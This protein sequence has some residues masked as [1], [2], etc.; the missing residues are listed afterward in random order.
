MFLK[1][2]KIILASQSPRRKEIFEKFGF[3]VEVKYPP[4]D[5]LEIHPDGSEPWIPEEIVCENAI[6]KVESIFPVENQW[7]VGSDTL[8]VLNHKAYGKPKDQEEAFAFLSELSGHTHQVYSGFCLKYNNQ[9]L[10]GW[11]QASVTFKKLSTKEIQHYVE[12]IPVLDKA[13]AYAVQEGGETIIEN[14]EG[15]YY[16][17]MGLPIE[18]ISLTMTQAMD[19]NPIKKRN[20]FCFFEKSGKMNLFF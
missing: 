15:S 14:L 5:L 4:K 20:L 9:R 8:V 11:D 16:T 10:P 13:G 17:V 1:K 2:T 19:G 3:L 12:T 18:K 7:M 6:R